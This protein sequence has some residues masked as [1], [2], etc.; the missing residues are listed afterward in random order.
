MCQLIET[1]FPTVQFSS[2][3]QLCLTLCDPM[4]C[5]MAGFPVYHQLL[6]LAQTHVHRVSDVIQTA[7]PLSCPSPPAFNLSQHQGLFKWVSCSHQ[8]A[9][10]LE[11][12]LQ[13]QSFL[14]IQDWFPLGW[15]DW[16]SLQSKGLSRVFSNTT[17]WKHQFFGTQQ[18][19]SPWQIPSPSILHPYCLSCVLSFAN[20]LLGIPLLLIS[21]LLSWA[22]CFGD[23]YHYCVLYRHIHFWI[24][25]PFPF[26]QDIILM[27]TLF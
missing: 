27:E 22:W 25:K 20:L 18:H 11:F 26:I 10:V 23:H 1:V 3:T 19:I 5:S 9:K 6:E 4:N 15:T 2:F 21:S 13:H 24:S 16:I 12:Q 17:V 14:N 7:H 8:V